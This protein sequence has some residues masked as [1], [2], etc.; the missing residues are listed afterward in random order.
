MIY[1]LFNLLGKINDPFMKTPLLNQFYLYK[2]IIYVVAPIF[3][4]IIPS[5]DIFV[6]VYSLQNDVCIYNF[7]L[8]SYPIS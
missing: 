8:L 2:N 1:Y 6:V 5:V 3:N 4:V 7:S